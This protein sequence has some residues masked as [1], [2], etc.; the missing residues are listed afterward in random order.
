[1]KKLQYTGALCA[2]LAIVA[3]EDSESKLTIDGTGAS[4]TPPVLA[5]PSVAA[6]AVTDDNLDDE[7][8]FKWKKSDFGLPVEVVY[9]LYARYNNGRAALIATDKGVDSL[10]VKVDL[11]NRKAIK[12]GAPKDAMSNIQIYVTATASGVPN[13]P[14]SNDVSFTITTKAPVIPA[15]VY[16]IGDDFGS[17]G[18]ESD[19][20]VEMIPVNSNE[21]AGQEGKFW[22]VR[23]FTKDKGFK[24]ST[25]RAWVGDFYSLGTNEGF[26]TKDGNAFVAANGFYIVMM[27]YIDAKITIASAN[28]YGIGDCFGGGEE[29][30]KAANLFDENPTNKTMTK[31]TTNAGNVRMYAAFEDSG[32]WWRMEFVPINGRIEYRGNGGDQERVSV[33]AGKTITLNFNA[34]TGVIE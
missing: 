2:L 10:V 5:A 31:T 16:M 20:V 21:Y 33:A 22:C 8:V 30:G 15:N 34:G 11:L 12:A 17:W 28:I 19:G 25:T 29:E 9:T 4:A 18:W 13:K 1:M 26:S 27:D 6:V 3:C 24:W 32:E 7:V 14:A 23:Y